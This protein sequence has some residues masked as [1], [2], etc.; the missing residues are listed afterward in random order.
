MKIYISGAIT[1]NPNYIEQ[2]ATAEKK[3]AAAGHEVINPAKNQG[4]S[5]KQYIDTGLFELMNCEAIYLLGGYEYS[6]GARL[7]YEYAKAVGLR[8]IK[9]IKGVSDKRL[10]KTEISDLDMYELAYNSCYIENG[11]LRYRDLHR[12]T[13]IHDLLRQLMFSYGVWNH[14][15]EIKEF[16]GYEQGKYEIFLESKLI[17]NLEY[18]VTDIRGLLA[19]LYLELCA[20]AKMWEKLKKYEDLEE[21]EE[22]LIN[23][24]NLTV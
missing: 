19:L 22:C 24:E 15:Q 13:D 18:G 8:I 5:Y 9:E 14:E 4:Y 17:G 6:R 20:K 16:Y 3:L 11:K 7:E 10:T 1:N 23:L 12:D 2:F 21:H